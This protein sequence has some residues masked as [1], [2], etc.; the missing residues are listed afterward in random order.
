[1]TN[2]INITCGIV[3]YNDEDDI[4]QVI[5]SLLKQ[6][7]SFNLSQI[8]VWDNAS[9][10]QTVKKVSDLAAKYSS[11]SSVAHDKNLVFGQAHNRILDLVDSDYHII[12][13]PDII[14][15]LGAIDSLVEMMETKYDV[16]LAAPRVHYPDGTLQPLNKREP[17][18]ATLILRRFVHSSL[19]RYFQT[20]LDR[21]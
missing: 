12:C 3:T 8:I 4:S 19:H 15:Q 14:V 1:M 16:G 2:G 20:I 17:R 21:F 10:D 5:H 11:V 13:N 9:V 18:M 6:K 7:G